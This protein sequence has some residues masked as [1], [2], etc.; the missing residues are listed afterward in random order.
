MKSESL[1]FY[2]SLALVA[3]YQ[4]SNSLSSLFTKRAKIM[5]RSFIMSESDSLFLSK[6]QAI[7]TKNKER[8]PNP[9]SVWENC[10]FFIVNAS[11]FPDF[12]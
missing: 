1:F 7:R 9:G 2:K 5:I 12:L 6:K 10:P 8:I 3:L 11:D 4:K